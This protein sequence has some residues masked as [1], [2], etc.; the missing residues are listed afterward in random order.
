MPKAEGRASASCFRPE[1]AKF[2]GRR[3]QTRMAR[4]RR[5]VVSAI[6]V[7]VTL[8]A[9]LFIILILL[10]SVGSEQ[11]DSK[12]PPVRTELVFLQH[13][14]PGGGGGG[15][16]Q[17][18]PPARIEIPPP[19]PTA[20]ALVPPDV[21]A[22]APPPPSLDA[23]IQ[24]NATVLLGNGMNPFAAPAPGGGGRGKGLGLGDGDGL[25][26]GNDRGTGGGSPRPGGFTQPFP[27]KEV[28]PEYT[29]PAL[30]AKVQ[31]SVTLE[32]EVLAN[33]TVGYVKVVKS[34]DRSY[35]LDAQA[36]RAARQWVFRPATAGGKPV[37]SVVQLIL[38]FNL[39]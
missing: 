28:K 10:A 18:A 7:S 37:D 20:V 1:P 14:G 9:A 36:I 4:T 33:G 31:G 39:R 15:N 21:I 26:A 32:V 2:S 23:P 16:P 34:L 8:H 11:I 22:P 3:V 35:G 17:P 6:G 25:E 27:I 38:D 12:S 29:G 30:Q 5:P 19:H 13:A 24:A